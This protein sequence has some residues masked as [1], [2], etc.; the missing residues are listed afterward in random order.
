MIPYHMWA[1]RC[2]SELVLCHLVLHGK[3]VHMGVQFLTFLR[4]QGHISLNSFVG[5]IHCIHILVIKIIE[6]E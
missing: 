2:T 3:Y 4:S 6:V 1:T 5:R